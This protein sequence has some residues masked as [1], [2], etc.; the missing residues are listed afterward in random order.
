MY[1]MSGTPLTKLL[2]NGSVQSGTGVS[3]MGSKWGSTEFTAVRS[4]LWPLG[5]ARGFGGSFAIGDGV[6]LVL[7]R[8]SS[9]GEGLNQSISAARAPIALMALAMCYLAA[10]ASLISSYQRRKLARPPHHNEELGR[11]RLA[12]I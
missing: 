6:T 5:L 7:L 10:L 1:K 4:L 11:R 8:Q 3:C 2:H 9:P 12:P